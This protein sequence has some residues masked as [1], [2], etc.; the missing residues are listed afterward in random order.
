MRGKQE[1][2]KN[3]VAVPLF[4]ETLLCII[5][6]MQGK[7]LFWKAQQ[8]LQLFS[9]TSENPLT[10]SW[11]KPWV[12]CWGRMVQREGRAYSMRKSVW[13]EDL[14]VR[15]VA[16][17]LQTLCRKQAISIRT[18]RSIFV[19][20]VVVGGVGG[21]SHPGKLCGIAVLDTCTQYYHCQCNFYIFEKYTMPRH[22][23]WCWWWWRLGGW[24]ATVLIFFFWFSITFSAQKR[25]GIHTSCVCSK[26]EN[27]MY[28]NNMIVLVIVL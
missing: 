28:K 17:I 2:V 1:V 3:L 22:T 21:D 7:S 16:Y 6:L 24:C 8:L 19:H 27:S 14:A 26:E 11:T 10:F 25:C 23:W 9:V 15:D 5:I 4:T 13:D 20:K 12:S 18:L